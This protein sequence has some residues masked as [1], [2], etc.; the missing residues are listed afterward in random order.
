MKVI[1]ENFCALDTLD[2][3]KGTKYDVGFV[4]DVSGSIQPDHWKTEKTFVKKLTKVIKVSPTVGRAA[5]ALFSNKAQLNIKFSDKTF[6]EFERAVDGMK[7][8]GGGTNIGSGLKVAL[9]Q[10]FQISNGMRP[11]SAKTLI[12]ITDG[13]DHTTDY[14][15]FATKFR[16]AN[17]K[18]IVIGV[19]AVDTSALSKL[20][21]DQATDLYI[22][23][24]FDDLKIGSF[25]KNVGESICNGMLRKVI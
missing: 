23:A 7:K 24:K 19:G 1:F 3:C 22:A 5:V 17:I 9:D 10:M 25:F 16:T 12:L 14:P 21:E 4:L 15:A 20:V 11:D 18:V 2:K 8:F 13:Q 6:T